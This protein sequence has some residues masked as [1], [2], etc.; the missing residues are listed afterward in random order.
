MT[1]YPPQETM[2]YATD[3]V[4]FAVVCVGAALIILML[5]KYWPL[6]RS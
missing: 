4:E 2:V 3:R 5:I 1:V 6:D